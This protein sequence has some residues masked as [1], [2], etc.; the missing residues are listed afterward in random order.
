M[1][2][3]LLIMI[4]YFTCIEKPDSLARTNWTKKIGKGQAWLGYKLRFISFI[5]YK[6]RG[7]AFADCSQARA[8]SFQKNNFQIEMRN[9]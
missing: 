3:G 6:G 5:V 2:Y 1:N 4:F 9:W 8:V 7:T